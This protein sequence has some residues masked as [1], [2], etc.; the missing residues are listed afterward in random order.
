MMARHGQS[1]LAASEPTDH[2][3]SNAALT[4]V[5]VSAS[6]A[7]TSCARIRHELGEHVQPDLGRRR[8]RGEVIVEVERRRCRNHAKGLL[9]HAVERARVGIDV[10]GQRALAERPTRSGPRVG[11]GRRGAAWRHPGSW[12]QRRR[13]RC[14][15]DRRPRWGRPDRRSGTRRSRSPLRRRAAAIKVAGD[16]RAHEV[17][18]GFALVPS[19]QPHR[20]SRRHWRPREAARLCG[21]RPEREGLDDLRVGVDASPDMSLA[22]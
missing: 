20:S 13:R 18:R 3:C 7:A 17:H 22:R 19:G 8:R 4:A 2:C 15:P 11:S 10:R 14:R 12:R 1:A 6:S 5:S 16:P 9:E 21:V